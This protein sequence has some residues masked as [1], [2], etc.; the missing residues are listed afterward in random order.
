MVTLANLR[1]E[2]KA[3]QYGAAFQLLLEEHPIFNRLQ[4]VPA[5]AGDRHAYGRIRGVATAPSFDPDSTMGSGV[6]EHTDPMVAFIR[7]CGGNI[8]TPIVG[9]ALGSQAD[10]I[11]GKVIA[12]GKEYQNIFYGGDFATL[13]V[14]GSGSAAFSLLQASPYFDLTTRNGGGILRTRTVSPVEH[15]VSFRYAGD[16]FGTEQAVVATDMS[17]ALKSQNPNLWV[18]CSIDASALTDAVGSWYDEVLVTSTSNQSDGVITLAR[19]SQTIDVA[20]GTG[21]AFDLSHLD[22]VIRYTKGSNKVV[23]MPLE[24]YD[25]FLADCRTLGGITLTEVADMPGILAYRRVPIIPDEGCPHNVTF[26][27]TPNLGVICCMDLNDGIRGVYGTAG[28]NVVIDGEVYGGLYIR[29]TGELEA[30]DLQR[31]RVTGYFGV[32]HFNYQGLTVLRGITD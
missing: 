21:E 14:P 12:V 4:W 20:T 18:S 13:T 23:T 3:T 24:T 5:N 30:S 27:A 11:R 6:D 28:S 7:P 9:Q 10:R 17:V 25:S 15:Y 16:A 8:D 2:A 29:N 26:N 22:T 31:T 1:D 19:G 32:A